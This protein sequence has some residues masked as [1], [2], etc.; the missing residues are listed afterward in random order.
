M[1]ER[2][3]A[4]GV[5]CCTPSFIQP[6]SRIAIAASCCS[7][8]C[9]GSLRS[10]ASLVP[11]RPTSPTARTA[12]SAVWIK[13]APVFLQKFPDRT[14]QCLLS[15]WI[16]DESSV[17]PGPSKMDRCGSTRWTAWQSARLV[18]GRKSDARPR[19][20]HWRVLRPHLP[21][22]KRPRSVRVWKSSLPG[23]ARTR[24]MSWRTK[25]LPPALPQE[26]R[27]FVSL[28]SVDLRKGVDKATV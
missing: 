3:S 15:L 8:H 2:N 16:H 5:C 28:S 14:E 27:T 23:S 10:I 9:A 6:T 18:D 24:L 12:L 13:R 26:P 1:A 4:R 11:L 7:R 25:T 17:S 19:S 21:R 20:D 22:S